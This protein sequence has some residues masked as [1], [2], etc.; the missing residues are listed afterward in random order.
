MF[1]GRDVSGRKEVKSMSKG[2]LFSIL[3]GVLFAMALMI[4]PAHAD[5]FDQAT[6]LKFNT[7]IQLPNFVL[8]AGTYWF[9]KAPTPDE[10]ANNLVQIYNADHSRL[11]ATLLTQNVERLAPTDNTVLR[12]GDFSHNKPVA[13]VD[14]FYPG[15]VIGDHFIYG[16]QQR[17]QLQEA[18]MENVTPG[19]MTH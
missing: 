9:Q 10:P 7:P 13:V 2:K 17:R 1:R 12:L 8:P 6:M 18:R 4:A 11:L 5:E 19:P 16:T 14:W 15:E 3:A